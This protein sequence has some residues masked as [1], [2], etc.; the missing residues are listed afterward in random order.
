MAL[1]LC[2]PFASLA[3]SNHAPRPDTKPAEY[4]FSEGFSD[5]QGANNWYYKEWDGSRYTDMQWDATAGRWKGRGKSCQ[6]WQGA[7][8]P[9]A[10]DAVIA[11]KAPRAGD[12]T[13]QGVIERP[14][15]KGDGTRARI[16]HNAKLIWPSASWQDV[17]PSFMVQHVCC[18]QVKAGEWIYF[19]LNRWGNV[20]D[21]STLWDP[22]I[23]YDSPPRFVVD[24]AQRVMVEAGLQRMKINFMDASLCA[25]LRDSGSRLFWFHSEDNGNQHQ[26]FLGTLDAPAQEL[27]FKKAASQLFTANPSKADGTWW[28]TN[29]Y[30]HTDM[31][32]GLVCTKK[33]A[34]KTVF[35]YL[36]QF[37]PY[38]YPLKHLLLLPFYN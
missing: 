30:R 14:S 2:F 7:A 32:F 23:R 25:L 31:A 34:N 24:G 26:K 17:Y 10:T 20:D 11:W 4:R 6:V 3:D 37:S 29:I 27:V 21:D 35:Y 9:D 19:H 12:I 5:E 16:V 18:I 33:C 22:T 38:F 8:H 28:L 15:P 13:V 1:L 36:K